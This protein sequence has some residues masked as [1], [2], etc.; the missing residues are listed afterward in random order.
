MQ[1]YDEAKGK[2]DSMQKDK[3]DKQARLNQMKV[4]RQEFLEAGCK[5]FV[6]PAIAVLYC[7]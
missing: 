7:Q 2:F 4:D 3:K 6:N 1:E 5:F